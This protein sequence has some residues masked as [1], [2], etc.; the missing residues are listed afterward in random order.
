MIKSPKNIY[1]YK[2]H[3]HIHTRT[4]NTYTIHVHKHTLKTDFILK[5][6]HGSCR[7]LPVSIALTQE[8]T[9]DRGVIAPYGVFR[10][11][12]FEC[13]SRTQTIP[14]TVHPASNPLSTGNVT[15]NVMLEI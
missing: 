8:A 1:V 15:A 2:K 14:V 9:I 12:C 11:E 6:E 3:A 5:P 7:F 4:Y 10:M 13:C